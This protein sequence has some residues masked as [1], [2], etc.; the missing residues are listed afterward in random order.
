MALLDPP[1]YAYAQILVKKLNESSELVSTVD[2]LSNRQMRKYF[3][4]TVRFISDEK[5]Y[6]AMLRLQ[7]I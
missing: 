4:I 5:L 1:G 7:T 6:N 2:F 3:A